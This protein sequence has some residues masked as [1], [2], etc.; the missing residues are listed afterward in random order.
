MTRICPQR[1]A[2]AVLESLLYSLLV[3][4]VGEGVELLRRLGRGK[5]I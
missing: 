4:G 5:G 3:Q 2:L 1:L